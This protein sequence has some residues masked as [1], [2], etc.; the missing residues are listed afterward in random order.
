MASAE[1][2]NLDLEPVAVARYLSCIE[3]DLPE[4]W[5]GATQ[6]TDPWGSCGSYPDDRGYGAGV[7]RVRVPAGLLGAFW[8]RVS[9][10]YRELPPVTVGPLETAGLETC[11]IGHG[12]AAGSTRALMIM[13]RERLYSSAYTAGGA[14]RIAA[15]VEDLD[16]VLALDQMSFTTR[17]SRTNSDKKNGSGSP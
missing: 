16:E 7:D 2:P 5:P 4:L 8:E 6:W 15:T 13:P 10:E 1:A 9:A 14:A 17:R 11:L 12:Y 3:Q